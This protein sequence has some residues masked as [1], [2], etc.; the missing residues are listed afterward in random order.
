[1]MVAVLALAT[2]ALG[3]CDKSRGMTARTYTLH[4][5]TFQ[6]ASTLLT[7]YIAEGGYLSGK[8]RFITVRERP[9]RLDSIAAI[10]KRFDGAPQTV[11]LRFQVIEAGDF[12][13]GDSVIARVEAPLREIFRYRGYRLVGEATVWTMQGGQFQQGQADLHI[14]GVVREATPT[15]PDARITLEL[16]VESQGVT[17]STT[18]SGLPGKTMIIG[19]QKRTG[20]G[21]IIAAVTPE[22]VTP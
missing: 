4:R 5:L 9:E 20:G 8:D 13:G 1:M 22:V 15:G 17:V 11:R 16:E 19:T 10:L 14:A 6:E 7:P 3:G 12:A 2:L 21:A 18:V